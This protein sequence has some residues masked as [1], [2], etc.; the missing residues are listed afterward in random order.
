MSRAR[1]QVGR[2]QIGVRRRRPGVNTGQRIERPLII[3]RLDEGTSEEEVR[4][5]E[6]GVEAN[7]LAEF[8]DGVLDATGRLQGMGERLV[9]DRTPREP[10]H[11]LILFLDRRGPLAAVRIGQ[12]DLVADHPVVRP[13]PPR[14]AELGGCFVRLSQAEQCGTQGDVSQG[15]SRPGVSS[16]RGTRPRPPR[17]GRSGGATSE[18]AQG[19]SA[20]GSDARGHGEEPDGLVRTARSQQFP[21]EIG[22][23]PEVVP[24]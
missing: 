23:D 4:R 10:A 6:S 19:N 14:L 2:L 16:A 8:R 18:A 11:R 5:G 3:A 24:M 7:G 17:A 21:P 12:G 13:E 22:I 15:V 1:R 20:P 9:G